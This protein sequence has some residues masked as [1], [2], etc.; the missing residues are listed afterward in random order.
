MTN[1]ELESLRQEILRVFPRTEPPRFED[2]TSDMYGDSPGV[3]VSFEAVR[4]WS[5]NNKIIDENYNSLPLLTPTAFHYYLPAFL[6][7]S[8]ERFEPGNRTLAFT[9][10]SL[11]PTKISRKDPWYSARLALFSPEQ[12]S[13]I[14]Q[15]LQLILADETMW[16]FYEPA[17]RGLRK[18]WN[19]ENFEGL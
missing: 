16:D 17:E 12:A 15:F 19:K 7:R 14:R 2:I 13:V 8:L 1:H 18:F 10:Y 4:W 6:L 3:R 11:S 5:A 9:I